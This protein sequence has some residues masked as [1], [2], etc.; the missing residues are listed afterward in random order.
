[1]NKLFVAPTVAGSVRDQVSFAE[2]SDIVYPFDT[3]QYFRQHFPKTTE[4]LFPDFD[5]LIRDTPAPS[6]SIR[7]IAMPIGNAAS[8]NMKKTT[9]I[10]QCLT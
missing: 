3:K 8:P 7:K 10:G 5:Q 9:G 2:G 1:M 4:I 6:N